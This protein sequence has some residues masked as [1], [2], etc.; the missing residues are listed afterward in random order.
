MNK[1]EIIRKIKSKKG[2]FASIHAR[3]DLQLKKDSPFK[4]VEKETRLSGISIGIA[5]DAI[6]KVKEARADGKL[7]EVNAGLQGREWEEF[8]YIQVNPKTKK[9]FLSIYPRQT[10][11]AESKYYADGREI[12]KADLEPYL[13]AKDKGKKETPATMAYPLDSILEIK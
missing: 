2:Q 7:P 8:P 10:F 12:N 11:H 5:Y 3:R 6:N 1:Q 4:R 13:Y 9:R